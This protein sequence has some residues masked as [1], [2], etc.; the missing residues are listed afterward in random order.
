MGPRLTAYRLGRTPTQGPRLRPG[1]PRRDWMDASPQGF[2][3]RCLPLTMANGH[4]WEIL[5][6]AG[7]EACWNGGQLP[8]DIAIRRRGE[9]ED[10]ECAPLPVSHFGCG[11]LTFHIPALFRTGPGISLW[12]GGPPNAVRDGIAPLT[13]IVE[14]D[15][16]PMTFTMN[17]RFTRPDHIIR[18]EPGEPVAFVFPL[19]RDLLGAT[20][21]VIAPMTPGIE[22]E[23]RAW[24]ASR[25]GFNAALRQDDK[26]A[27]A[28]GWQRDYHR[29]ARQT[30]P[31]AR[32]FR[33]EG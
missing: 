26:A 20:E 17:W 16:A 13:G 7:F 2:A 29:G 15:W 25:G 14:T 5:G 11:V 24:A 3:Y 21:P 9:A 12:V 31:G 22:A 10:P 18:F 8:G 6:G 28:Q 30:R 32:P 1:S 33:E 4:G 19:Q 27:R 23:H